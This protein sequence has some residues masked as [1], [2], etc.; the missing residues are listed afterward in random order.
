MLENNKNKFI[1]HM[2]IKN[3]YSSRNHNSMLKF[4]KCQYKLPEKQQKLESGENN[5][6]AEMGEYNVKNNI[7][8]IFLLNIKT[9]IFKYFKY[10]QKCTLLYNAKINI[11]YHFQRKCQYAFA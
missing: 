3:Y 1:H 6:M 4:F 7:V 11:N 9:N 8:Y 10:Y 5:E 2:Y